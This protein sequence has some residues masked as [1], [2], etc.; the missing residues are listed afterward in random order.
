MAITGIVLMGFVFVHMIGN[1]KMYLG[2]AEFDHY[3]EFLRELLV[4]ILPRTV[5]PVDAAD[6]ADRWRSR[7][8]S[9]PRTR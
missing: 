9:T 1:L 3:A 7:C 2:P 5:V 6:R 8:T 4:P